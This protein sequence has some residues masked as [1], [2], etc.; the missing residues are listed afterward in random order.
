MLF[1][2]YPLICTYVC[3]THIL[4]IFCYYSPYHTCI[5]VAHIAYLLFFLHYHA[6]TPLHFAHLCCLFRPPPCHACIPI[7]H[8]SRI[9]VICVFPPVYGRVFFWFIDKHRILNDVYFFFEHINVCRRVFLLIY[10]QCVFLSNKKNKCIFLR[11]DG[12]RRLQRVKMKINNKKLRGIMYA[13]FCLFNLVWTV[14]LCIGVFVFLCRRQ[15][16][17]SNTLSRVIRFCFLLMSIFCIS[18]VSLVH[19]HIRRKININ[20]TA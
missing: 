14:A 18:I 6:C 3:I 7:A 4:R 19:T 16:S 15:F 5:F 10:L 9:R 8:V 17:K 20:T 2:F 1:V 13:R 11:H 12:A